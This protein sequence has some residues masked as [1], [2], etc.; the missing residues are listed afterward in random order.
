MEKIQRL[1]N[2]YMFLISPFIVHLAIYIK[3]KLRIVQVSQ[4][5]I[6]KKK[7]INLL[8]LHNVPVMA[9]EIVPSCHPGWENMK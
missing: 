8:V 1:Q 4:K 3:G 2:Y 9:A 5:A 6:S 7:D